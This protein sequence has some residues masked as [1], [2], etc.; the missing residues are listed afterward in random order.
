[1]A[2]SAPRYGSINQAVATFGLGRS[3]LY[4]LASKH[5]TLLRKFGSKSLVDY[6]VLQGLI[7]GLPTGVGRKRIRKESRE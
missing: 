5:P 3:S 7:D 1:M 6:G 2:D 4:V